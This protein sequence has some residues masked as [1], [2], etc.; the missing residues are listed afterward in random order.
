[1]RLQRPRAPRRRP[2]SPPAAMSRAAQAPVDLP[3]QVSVRSEP[4]RPKVPPVHAPSSPATLLGAAF[5]SSSSDAPRSWRRPP[6]TLRSSSARFGPLEAGE[7]ALPRPLGT[8]RHVPADFPQS[9]AIPGRPVTESVGGLSIQW[10]S[11]VDPQ[12]I[13]WRHA[14]PAARGQVRRGSRYRQQQD[15]GAAEGEFRISRHGK[16]PA[17]DRF[18]RGRLFP[19]SLDPAERPHR[20]SSC[21]RVTAPILRRRP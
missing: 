2:R 3:W 7:S 13:H 11:S 12:R 21:D 6:A 17:F 19:G 18:W 1:M 20:K 9:S 16:L 10:L 8:A 15:C 14:N 4:A 5:Q